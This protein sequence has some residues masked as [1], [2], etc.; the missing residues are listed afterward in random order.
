[1]EMNKL[2]LIINKGMGVERNRETEKKNGREREK[3]TG[4]KQLEEKQKKKQMKSFP[5]DLFPSCTSH[6]EYLTVKLMDLINWT[7]S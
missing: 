2:G 5:H 7:I 1:M 4:N 3:K 6:S